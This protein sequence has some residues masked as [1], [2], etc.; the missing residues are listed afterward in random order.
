MILKSDT[1]NVNAPIGGFGN[2]VRTLLLLSDKFPLQFNNKIVAHKFDKKLEII[3]TLCYP[4]QKT[5]DNWLYYEW[6]TREH[7]SA[8]ILFS[9]DFEFI[10]NNKNTFAKIIALTINPELCYRCYFKIN[11][12]LNNRRR[13]NFIDHI[14]SS[15]RETLEL[16]QQD[17]RVLPIEASHL[18]SQTLD[19]KFYNNII[20]WFDVEDRYETACELH[21]TW[22]NLHIKAEKEFVQYVN[23]FY[24]EA[25]HK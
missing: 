25:S 2:H 18:F 13:K 1:Y 15:N 20:H 22:Y 4:P 9:H 10:K 7:F 23:E 14:E 12:N 5:W 11:S 19:R 6:Q 3:K 16:A 21:N 24:G 8:E 17:N